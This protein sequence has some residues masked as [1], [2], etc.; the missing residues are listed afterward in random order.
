MP[1]GLLAGGPIQMLF[2]LLLMQG[3][4]LTMFRT[5]L[6]QAIPRFDPL[7][8]SINLG[9]LRDSDQ[10]RTPNP[11]PA[12]APIPAPVVDPR[13]LPFLTLLQMPQTMVPSM[14]QMITTPQ[15][16]IQPLAQPITPQVIVIPQL[17]SSASTHY[18][19]QVE[20]P[21]EIHKRMLRRPP[22]TT[23]RPKTS[24]L[25]KIDQQLDNKSLNISNS[26]DS[27]DSSNSINSSKGES[28]LLVPFNNSSLIEKS[29]KI[30]LI[31][32][33]FIDF[34]NEMKNLSQTESVQSPDESRKEIS[35]SND[36]KG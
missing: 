21:P 22:K 13:I 36:S 9:N 28:L 31:H 14:P 33:E 6:N 25:E 5:F 32:K 29:A 26:I 30:D 4:S 20:A 24:E 2:S 8:F 15:Q 23:Q 34:I 19:V 35:F 18:P 17:K 12:P 11:L 10:T 1:F 7:R 16:S 3:L 27:I